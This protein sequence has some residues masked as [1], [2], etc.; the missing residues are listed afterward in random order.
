MYKNWPFP[1][2]SF[3]CFICFL[4]HRGVL[5]LAGTS[6]FLILPIVE[7]STDARTFF[8]D[9]VHGLVFFEPDAKIVI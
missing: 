2:G 9:H 4:F 5:I 1:P 7:I 6:G 3:W 8:L